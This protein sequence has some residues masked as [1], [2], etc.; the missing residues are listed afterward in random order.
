MAIVALLII[1]VIAVTVYF[2]VCGKP[3]LFL[4]RLIEGVFGIEERR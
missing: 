1:G 2:V 3:N 4:F